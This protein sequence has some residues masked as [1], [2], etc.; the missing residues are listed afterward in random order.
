MSEEIKASKRIQT[1]VLN[2]AEH[3]AL[4]WLAARQPRWVTSNMLTIVGISGAVII[5]AGYILSN[6]DIRWLWLATFGWIVNWYGDSLDGNLARYRNTGRPIYGYYLDHTVDAINE[7]F[8]FVGIGLSALLNIWIAIVGLI[9]YL[10]LTLNVSMNAHLKKEFRLTYI[11]M[12]PTELRIIMIIINT[13]F[14]FIRPLREFSRDVELFGSSYSL[15]ALDIIGGIIVA[16]LAVVYVVTIF[17]D[18]DEYAK[19]DPPK[20]WNG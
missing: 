20:K 12:G 15:G 19:M 14:I 16:A 10:L 18:L 11:S 9:L 2:A 13:L 4:V 1:S 8:M 3:K 7:I 5:A 17:K 6:L